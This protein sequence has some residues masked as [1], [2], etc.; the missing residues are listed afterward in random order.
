MDEMGRLSP[1]G[2]RNEQ[3]HP[4]VI[5]LDNIRSMMNT[6]SIFRTS[7]AF[8]LEGIYLCGVTAC[9]PHREIHKTALGATES[10]AW[11]YMEDARDA[12]IRLK[13][14]G[15]QVIAVEQTTHSV[16]LADFQPTMGQKVALVFG[17]EV[18]GVDE[19]VLLQC[20][21]ALEVPQFGTKHSLN[22]AVTAGIVVWDMVSKSLLIQK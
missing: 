16:S 3:K 18:K 4:I 12:V 9:P 6:G 11:Q 19:E 10:V 21:M 20:N 14:E 1:E 8:R 17:N 13:N 15:Y 22:V 5:V 2:F 7:D